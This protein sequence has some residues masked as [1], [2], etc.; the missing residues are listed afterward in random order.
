[1]NTLR[2][3]GKAMLDHVRSQDLREQCGI[4]PVGEWANA[5]REEWNNHNSRMTEDRI[6]RVI[7]YNSLKGKRRPG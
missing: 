2:K 1:M 4:Q 3:V 7:G 6:V 5:R